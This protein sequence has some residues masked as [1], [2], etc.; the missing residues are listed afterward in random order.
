MIINDKTMA[1]HIKS[2]YGTDAEELG[3][4]TDRG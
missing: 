4:P 2:H 1:D 3:S